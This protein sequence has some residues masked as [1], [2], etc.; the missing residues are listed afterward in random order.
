MVQIYFVWCVLVVMYSGITKKT[1]GR[2]LSNISRT[3][4]IT[5]APR[6]FGDKETKMYLLSSGHGIFKLLQFLSFCFHL[7]CFCLLSQCEN[8]GPTRSCPLSRA[9]KNQESPTPGHG[10]PS[11]FLLRQETK[12]IWSSLQERVGTV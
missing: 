8:D 9:V 7:Q 2:N 3:S 5:S 4:L 1:K 6:F 10:V 12:P 11:T